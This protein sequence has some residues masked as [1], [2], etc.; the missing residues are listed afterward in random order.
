MTFE[1]IED[2][3]E[4]ECLNEPDSIDEDTYLAAYNCYMEF[5]SLRNMTIVR[6]SIDKVKIDHETKQ[7]TFVA[8]RKETK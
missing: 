8:N 4:S 3:F 5:K 7:I 2:V 1:E 6:Y